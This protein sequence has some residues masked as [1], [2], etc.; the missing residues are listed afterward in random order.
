M[1]ESGIPYKKQKPKQPPDE[2]G[3]PPP[4]PDI[5]EPHREIPPPN[6]SITNEPNPDSH[7][8]FLC[9]ICGRAFNTLEKLQAHITTEHTKTAS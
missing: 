3:I 5:P 2:V 8:Q 4:S 7:T 1:T 9:K 6:I